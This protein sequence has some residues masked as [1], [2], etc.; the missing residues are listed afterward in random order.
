ME[1][2][3]RE[4]MLSREAMRC[5]EKTLEHYRYSVGGFVQWLMGQGI[6]DPCHITARDMRAYVLHVQRRCLKDTTIHAIARGIKTFIRFLAR[7]G[8]ID[9]AETLRIT[10]PRLDKR[11]LP[12][13]TAAD[14][15]ALL[16]VCRSTRD[17]AMIMCLL[18]TGCRATEFVSL[19]VEDINLDTGA[20]MIKQGKGRKDRIVYIGLVARRLLIRYLR[21]TGVS[22]A[23]WIARSGERLTRWGLREMLVRLGKAAGVGNCSPHAFRRTCALMSLRNGMDIFSLQHLLG[24]SDLTVLRRYLAQVDA[25]LAQAHRKYGVGDSLGLR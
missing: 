19:N 14:I 9:H 20:V 6:V 7:E 1:L 3:L 10:M 13:L 12:A 24:H 17:A 15:N 16:G 11:I 5:T 25:D 22:D 8:V 4:F 2:M 21:E 23:L 18:D